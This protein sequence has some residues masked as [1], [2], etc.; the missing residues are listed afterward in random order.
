MNISLSIDD[1][2]VRR[3]DDIAKAMNRSRSFVALQAME[4]YVSYQEWFIASV[5]EAMSEADTGGVFVSHAEML[6][7]ADAREK[8]ES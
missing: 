6:A 8:R 3:I 1:A 4:Q 2:M 7:D 5:E